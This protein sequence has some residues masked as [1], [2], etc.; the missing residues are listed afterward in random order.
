VR[1]IRVLLGMLFAVSP[2]VACGQSFLLDGAVGPTIN[3]AG[4]S[5]AGGI[6]FT[7]AS[8]VAI[9]VDLERTHLSSELQ[10]DRRGGVHGFRGGTLTLA[11]AQLRIS[12][13][14]RDRIGPYGVVGYAAGVSRP[15]VN[16]MFPDAVTNHVHAM[17]FGGGIHIPLRERIGL[18]GDA[19]M[20]IGSEAGELL[21]VIPIR[22][23]IAWYF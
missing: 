7:P 12:L 13:L 4:Y 15:T 22:A 21:A 19:R 23:G 8:R 1:V 20:T 3:D 5:V 2:G 18:F 16:E 6:G 17:F 11:S 10:T 9:S 14:R